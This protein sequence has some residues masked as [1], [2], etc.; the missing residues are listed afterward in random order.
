MIDEILSYDYLGF[1]RWFAVRAI[2]ATISFALFFACA[3]T[4]AYICFKIHRFI[5]RVNNP[6]K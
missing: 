2:I 6:K 4:L 3:F 5:E 1:W